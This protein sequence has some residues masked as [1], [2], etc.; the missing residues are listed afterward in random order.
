MDD[1]IYDHSSNRLYYS[2]FGFQRAYPI[3]TGIIQP[4]S[5]LLVYV[6]ADE[7][8]GSIDMM[9]DRSAKEIQI[10]LHFDILFI[11]EDPYD[12]TLSDC[13]IFRAH[14]P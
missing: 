12:D 14:R 3:C 1:P 13:T 9:Q 8:K 5:F 11:I 6:C 10:W 2:T 4:Y 7:P